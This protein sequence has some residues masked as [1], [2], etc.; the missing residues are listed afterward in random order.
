MASTSGQSSLSR[1]RPI[2]IATV[3]G[4]L[5]Y[6]VF[7]LYSTQQQ[8][9][10]RLHRSN[11]V[12]RRRRHAEA[13]SSPP[14]EGRLESTSDTGLAAGGDGDPNESQ[15]HDAVDGRF[16]ADSVAGT[17]TLPQTRDGRQGQ[18]PDKP[19]DGQNLKQLLYYIAEEQ[20]RV[21]GYIHRGVSCNSCDT[22]PIRGIRWRCMNCP[23]YD[24]C[25]DCEAADLH[26]KT[27][28][29]YK[30]KIPA[31]F[32]GNP[33]QVQKVIYPGHPEGMPRNLSADLKKRLMDELS[34]ESHD[35]DAL[36]DQFTCLAD[37]SYPDDP[38]GL[39]GAI[40]RAAFDK[41]FVPMSSIN[42]PRPNLV[43]DRLFSSYDT[44]HDG[45]IG[46]EEF[47][48]G[49]ASTLGTSKKA[50]LKKAFDGYDMDSNG[51]ISRKDILLVFKAYYAIQKEIS[52]DVLAH[53]E[54]ENSL[55]RVWSRLMPA[56]Q[57]LSSAFHSNLATSLSARIPPGKAAD[58]FGEKRNQSNPVEPSSADN[59]SR[60]DILSDIVEIQLNGLDHTA[61]ESS[62][63]SV[64][65]AL[66]ARWHRR[67][68][69]T[70]QDEDPTFGHPEN[71]QPSQ[72]HPFEG[73]RKPNPF[74]IPE[75][76]ASSRSEIWLPE[77]EPDYGKEIL[78]Q[79]TQEGFNDLLDDVFSPRENED[80]KIQETATERRKW[81]REIRAILKERSLE[82]DIMRNPLNSPSESE[83]RSESET[84][85]DSESESSAENDQVTP[86]GFSVNPPTQDYVDPT[87]PQNMPNSIVELHML[88]KF[89]EEQ[90]S[91]A[92][93]SPSNSVKSA[94][95]QSAN[96]GDV[97]SPSPIKLAT[98]EALPQERLEYLAGLQDLESRIIV[99]GGPGRISFYDFER[100]MTGPSGAKL[101]FL[102]NWLDLGSF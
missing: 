81:R 41:A 70:D 1:Y 22:K 72:A 98:Q 56:S 4:A 24:L 27:H 36:Y 23:D 46:F 20:N 33:R 53:Q 101:A 32:F 13:Q 17:E 9:P 2:I 38:T 28:I 5:A 63:P 61:E 26:P 29:F 3:G 82:T 80:L 64:Q 74:S 35:L 97:T 67:A 84:S 21:D 87:M 99:A 91:E 76:S 37:R 90:A 89:S 12:H 52:L 45:F 6:S 83:T 86:S 18:G 39:D 34:Y 78:F 65:R 93:E 50:R 92:H 25:S 94:S 71:G 54:E 79:L 10:K 44:N 88:N 16:E 58:E 43:Y 96:A 69:Y 19:S 102:E 59:M 47:L 60:F 66:R 100:V 95:P 75:L 68:F 51:F 49:M 31:P 77:P 14:T 55:D 57:P 40:S 85:S 62:A 48:N 7:L 11:A 8:S 42:T 30:V 73:R 15:P